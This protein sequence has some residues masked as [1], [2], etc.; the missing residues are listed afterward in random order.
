MRLR[1]GVL[2][3]VCLGLFLPFWGQISEV[4]RLSLGR[5]AYEKEAYL[6]ALD[7]IRTVLKN[8]PSYGDAYRYLAMVYYALEQYQE[9]LEATQKA[10][11][12]NR[13]DTESSILMGNCYRELKE[14]T[15]AEKVYQDILKQYPAMASAHRELGMLYLRQ[16]RLSLAYQSLQRALRYDAEDWQNVIALGKYYEVKG[17]MREAEA[18]FAKALRMEPRRRETHLAL[19]EFYFQAGRYEEAIEV[20]RRA[21]DLFDHFVSGR[22]VLGDA[23]LALGM[24]KEAI[25]H[26]EW[27]ENERVYHTPESLAELAYKMA[28]AYGRM[29]ESRAIDYYKKALELV[30]KYELY[31]FGYQEYLRVNEE[32]GSE[33]RVAEAA[34]LYEKAK[35]TKTSGDLKRYFVLLR[36]AIGIDPYLKEARFDLVSFYEEKGMW[37]EAYEELLVLKRFYSDV[38]I[39]DKLSRYEWRIARKEMVIDKPVRHIY[40]GYV[41][42]ESDFLNLAEVY[43]NVFL[44]YSKFFGKFKFSG[45]DIRQ[46][47]S[48]K[49]LLSLLRKER[50]G[51]FVRIGVKKGQDIVQVE[52]VDGNNTTIAM[53]TFPFDEKNMGENIWRVASWLDEVFPDIYL[54][55]RVETRSQ[56]LLAAGS[57]QGVKIGERWVGFERRTGEPLLRVVVKKVSENESLLE[58]VAKESRLDYDE[59]ERLYFIREKDFGEKDLT[60]LKFILGY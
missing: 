31:E 9:A 24:E 52:I 48:T 13:Q 5:Q 55:K 18:S 1:K 46:S 25:K 7:Y 30:P 3:V 51:F 58:A 2:F 26:Y 14:Y 42:V 28:L 44:E 20:L 23:Y 15:K 56:Y 17:N 16:N 10:L 34:R 45:G 27:L 21:V 19:G 47:N 33:E 40:Q 53:K 38:K 43:Q 54:L 50:L 12:Y 60:K 49:D 41:V 32:V 22:Q 36:R 37:A 29:K 11:R 57:L 8:N 6:D 35:K 59:K 39:R 4:E